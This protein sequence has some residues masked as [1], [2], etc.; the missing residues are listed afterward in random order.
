MA[1]QPP[2]GNTSTPP[3]GVTHQAFTTRD[4]VM[5]MISDNNK[6]QFIKIGELSKSLEYSQKDI[7]D[8]KKD[9]IEIKNEN[10]TLRLKVQELEAQLKNF[11]TLSNETNVKIDKVEDQNRRINLKFRGFAEERG[12]N[13]EMCEHKVIRAIETTLNIKVDFQRA[14][15]VGPFDP[16]KHLNKPR[17]IVAKFSHW[18]TREA[19]WKRRGELKE[20][21]GISVLE[22]LCAGT[23][24]VRKEKWPELTQAWKDGKIA[25]FNY[26][27]VVTK[28]KSSNFTNQRR[29]R[30]PPPS[31]GPRSSPARTPPTRTPPGGS[32]ASPPAHTRSHSPRTP[33]AER[34]ASRSPVT[35]SHK[36][37]SA[38]RKSRKPS[39]SDP[40]QDGSIDAATGHS[41]WSLPAPLSSTPALGHS[42]ANA[43]APS[44][45]SLRSSS[46]RNK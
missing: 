22:D 45:R 32:D 17:D 36:P 8:M 3:R 7:D 13:W 11:K 46:R 19:V 35:R 2:R 12:G 26:R 31:R 27:T 28:Q 33:I 10:N 6:E 21:R 44:P 38:S 1:P 43:E 14:H 23:M 9:M 40:S 42:G 37:D 5:R 24:E 16:K 29:P 15:R 41:A 4:E 18:K 20:R 34:T 25:Y 39:I 30:T